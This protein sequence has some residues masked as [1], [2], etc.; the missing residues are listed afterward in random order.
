MLL[1]TYVACHG[2]MILKRYRCRPC[3]STRCFYKQQLLRIASFLWLVDSAKI[4]PK[5]ELH[6]IHQNNCF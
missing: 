5:Y 6:N 3:A 1:L 4:L 2:R